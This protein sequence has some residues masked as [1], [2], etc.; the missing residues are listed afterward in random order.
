M[1]KQQ[2]PE[3]TVGA[4][5]FNPDGDLFLMRSHKWHDNY[6]VPGGHIELG[7]RIED[8]LRREAKEE[9]GLDIYDVELLCVQEFIYDDTFWEKK[10]FIFFDYVCKTNSTK[11]TLN[12]EAHEY[13]WVSIQ[14]AFEL[15]IDPYTKSAIEKYIERMGS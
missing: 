3:P 15:P 10:H 8:A 14:E 7:E 9:T 12:D 6:V 11:V 13:T 4:L 1:A 2:Y 5:I